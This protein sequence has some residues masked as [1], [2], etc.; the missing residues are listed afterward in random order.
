MWRR[1]IPAVGWIGLFVGT[2]LP[3]V[4][5]REA[6]DAARPWYARCL[7]GM[8]VGPTGAQF[9][10]S[11][12]SD[13]EYAARFHGGEITRACVEAGAEY[14][15]IWARDGDWAYYDSK[16][17]RKCPG[18]GDRD[19]LREAVEEGA[20]HQLPIIAYC[21]VQQGGHFL[22]DHPQ[23]AMVDANGERIGRFCFNSGYLEP[24]KQLLAEQLVYGIDGFHI[25]M[26]DQ[27]FGP[28]YGCWCEHCREQFQTQYGR[29]M[30]TGVTWDED[31]DRMLEF[32]YATSA[33]FEQALQR[34]VKELNPRATVDFNYHGNPPFSWEVGQRPVQ[35]AGNSDF[36]TG[37]TGVW[38]FSALTVGL[39]AQFYRAAFPGVPYQVAIQRGVRMYHDQT[40]RP[41]HDMRW[42]TFVLLAHGAFV[43]MID[44]T[45]YDGWLDPVAYARMGEVLQE[46]RRKRA[47]FGQPPIREV[48]LYFSARTR[49]WVGRE[50]PAEY[51]QSFQGAHKACVMEHIPFG[52]VFDES[53]SMEGLRQ[54]PVVCLAN[55][56]IVSEREVELLEQY[57]REGGKLL[58]TGHTGQFDHFGRPRED[59]PLERLIGAR[60]LKRLESADNWVEFPRA[61][62]AGRAGEAPESEFAGAVS[63][64]IPR[65]W[66]LLVKGPATVYA[67]TGAE[68]IGHLRKPHR[69]PRQ[70]RGQQ[71][72]DWPM[73][74]DTVVG[75]AVLVNRFGRGLVVTAAASPDYAT[76]SEHHV[77]EARKLLRNLI[78]LLHPDPEVR[79]SAP[80]NVE[81]VITDDAAQRTMRVHLIAYNSTPQ[82]TAAKNR[83]YIIPG[84]VEEQPMYRVSL[85]STR[86]LIS[87]TPYN[88]STVLTRD[89]DRIELTI[90]DI[91]EVLLLEY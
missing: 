23:F 16:V 84:L 91:H 6:D 29:P 26:L 19:V 74:A 48:G 81:V 69:S 14:L 88:P 52:V 34:Y 75:P 32:R 10:H 46:A 65:N 1:G 56:G 43:T 18:L 28:P 51:F 40:T 76:A 59:A 42:E 73:S 63:R 53:V 86:P 17:A 2:C 30:P 83:P 9:G 64:D 58:I 38:G 8:E 13:T 45:A 54:F 85:V 39:N 24:M 5:A 80:S 60:P 47:H 82:T 25:D 57:V 87:A 31:W 71:T 4:A 79:V 21:V 67:C 12:P 33:R 20:R 7:V 72:T 22:Q 78:R 35:H 36:V 77:V 61:D 90:D 49:D 11:D 68:P 50:N 66:P 62:A 3:C 89:G 44:K 41:L 55:V 37:E 15:V 27:G 70:L